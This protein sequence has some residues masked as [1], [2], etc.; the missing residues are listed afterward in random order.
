[1]LIEIYTYFSILHKQDACKRPSSIHDKEIKKGKKI[2]SFDI[3]QVRQNYQ[4]HSTEICPIK[5]NVHS[6]PILSFLSN[7]P[8]FGI[9]GAVKMEIFS[10][11][12]SAGDK[13][14]WK[15]RSAACPCAELLAGDLCADA[16]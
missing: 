9:N 11:R 8:A 5:T 15:N 7:S 14:L 3:F 12:K 13:W 6:L 4:T 1:M 10:R 2:S 16:L